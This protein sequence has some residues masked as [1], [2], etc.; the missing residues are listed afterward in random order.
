M[1]M[2]IENKNGEVPIYEVPSMNESFFVK[3]ENLIS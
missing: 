2:V 3:V 1:E